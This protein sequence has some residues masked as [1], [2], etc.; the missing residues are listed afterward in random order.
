MSASRWC[1][2]LICLGLMGCQTPEGITTTYGKRAGDGAV[3][4]NGT[5][6]LARLFADAG[7]RVTTSRFLGHAVQ[8]AE[9]VVW[10]PDTYELPTDRVCNFFETWLME[11]PNR[12]L[13]FVGR[14]Y[15]GAVD[16]WR[17]LI[18]H[19]EQGGELARLRSELAERKT[20]VDYQRFAA[21]EGERKECLWFDQVITDPTP[22]TRI[23]G[24]WSDPPV[25]VALVAQSALEPKSEAPSGFAPLITSPEHILAAQITKP[26]W[27]GGQIIATTGGA[28]LFNL[29]LVEPGHG[30]LAQRLVDLC[31]PPTGGTPGTVVFL[32]SD[33]NAPHESDG[34]NRP[35]WL[36]AFTIW[37]FNSILIHATLLG[38]VL[39]L[40]I[41]PVFGP[42]RTL[43]RA[44][45][46]KKVREYNFGPFFTFLKG[47]DNHSSNSNMSIKL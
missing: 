9:V 37:P 25:D 22:V 24:R 10:C 23:G 14:D 3:S 47:R 42:F 18:A 1:A 38:M 4:V 12:T 36:E 46:R 41:F 26:H 19:E 31:L 11:Q 5:S 16:Y 15:D 32:E 7:F 2:W 30:E 33:H 17:I 40:A 21:L 35:Y 29:G 28:W 13:V 39:C 27:R 8:Q 43:G 6:V 44:N 34:A 45:V 20:E